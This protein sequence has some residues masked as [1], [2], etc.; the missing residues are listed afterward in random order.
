MPN[1]IVVSLIVTACLLFL[2]L[3]WAALVSFHEK[4]K[5]AFSR[6]LLL[7]IVLPIP[8]L[9]LALFKTLLH[10]PERI[11][12]ILAE[13]PALKLTPEVFEKNCKTLPQISN[14][15][16]TI[17]DAVFK[18]VEKDRTKKS[19]ES[20]YSLIDTLY[21][22]INHFYLDQMGQEQ[23]NLARKKT[24]ELLNHILGSTAT[25]ANAKEDKWPA[26]EEWES[27][28]NNLLHGQ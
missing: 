17:L 18:L 10:F 8:Y 25:Y 16:F 1:S 19:S 12:E 9:F 28:L 2:F 22:E 15:D 27:R 5:R 24:V 20:S 7:S 3:F 14:A 21:D 23:P 13:F 4:E 6:F 11:R 26:Y